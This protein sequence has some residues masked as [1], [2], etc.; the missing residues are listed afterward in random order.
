MLCRFVEDSIKLNKCSIWFFMKKRKLYIWKSITKILK[1]KINE[2][3]VKLKE[4]RSFFVYMCVVVKSCFE[5]DLKEV[6]G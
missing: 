3:V 5:I 2:N 6:I 1:V 4:D